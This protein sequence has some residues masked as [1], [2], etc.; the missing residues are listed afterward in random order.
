MT[1]AAVVV[2]RELV[3]ASRRWQTYA[4]RA[5]FSLVLFGFV[6][7]YW[8]EQ[9]AGR[10]WD[11]HTLGRAGRKITEAWAWL[12]F[13]LLAIITPVVVAQA[14]VEEKTSRTLE[15]LTT[16]RLTPSR[17]LAGKL[18]S[19][20][21]VLEGLI[22]VGLPVVALCIS[23]GG[24][25]F[26]TVANGVLQATAIIVGMG[27]VAAFLALYADGPIAPAVLTWVWALGSWF[28][29]H[30]PVEMMTN[31]HSDHAQGVSAVAALALNEDWRIVGPLILNSV[32]AL[33]TLV[34]ASRVWAA[35]ASSDHPE[36]E[37]LSVGFW[38]VE[39]I[40]RRTWMLFVALLMAVPVLFLSDVI[41]GRSTLRPMY[42]LAVWGWAA[43]LVL[44]GSLGWLLVCRAGFR[45]AAL[46]QRNPVGWRRQAAAWAS[47]RELPRRA[48]TVW[49]NPVAWREIRTAAHGM[50]SH[51]LLRAYM[52]AGAIVVLMFAVIPPHDYPWRADDFVGWAFLGFFGCAVGAVFLSTSSIAAEQ[53]RRTLDLLRV[54]GMSPAAVL[55]GKLIAVAVLLAPPVLMSAVI[56][57]PGMVEWAD[58]W[59]YEWAVDPLSRTTIAALGL[60]WA[61]TCVWGVSALTFLAVSCMAL[62]LAARTPGRAWVATLSWAA[63]LLLAPVFLRVLA[64]RRWSALVEVLGF[65]NPG[66]N[67]AYWQQRSEMLWTLWPSAMFWF[68]ASGIVLLVTARRFGA[69]PAR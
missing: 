14:I 4:Q 57:I 35:M 53:R 58:D 48:R 36:D 37:A 49:G 67:E 68:F 62:A 44:A 2:E 34:L 21:L 31:P 60:R 7:I 25:E 56:L 47:G 10:A 3:R 9:V 17:I 59:R 45:Y 29:P 42:H 55:R 46:K 28:L 41:I 16:T 40:K 24:V 6:V 61:A 22:L 63:G 12:Q 5:I 52:V 8:E 18:I 64:Q 50:I 66:L 39:G 13:G 1:T 11:A 19:R 38:A 15:L 65:L 43:G 33:A 69:D 20:M 27:S 54:T 32:V 23:L 26:L 51:W 30:I